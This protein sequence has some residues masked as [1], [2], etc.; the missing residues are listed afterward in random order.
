KELAKKE[1]A[2]APPL[3][4]DFARKTVEGFLQSPFHFWKRKNLGAID[5]PV[6]LEERDF[7]QALL[8][9][10]DAQRPIVAAIWELAQRRQHLDN[11]YRFHQ[12]GRIW[13]LFHG[14]AAW[15]LFVLMLEHVWKSWRFGGF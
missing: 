7:T 12:L 3:V 13:L 1:F 4:L 8:L 2:A 14:P 9:A 15:A 11:E 10:L 5:A 6:A